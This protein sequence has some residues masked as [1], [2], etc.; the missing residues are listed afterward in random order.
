MTS[1]D[2]AYDA[3]IHGPRTRA[4]QTEMAELDADFARQWV[5]TM[6]ELVA[7]NLPDQE[8]TAARMVA[9]HEWE[10]A[11]KRAQKS[12]HYKYDP[13]RRARRLI[14]RDTRLTLEDARA[15]ATALRERLDAATAALT[16]LSTTDPRT[17]NEPPAVGATVA[18]PTT[19]AAPRR[20]GL[21]R[22]SP[23]AAAFLR[24]LSPSLD[25]ETAADDTIRDTWA[26]AHPHLPS[27][28]IDDLLTFLNDPAHR[29]P[30]WLA[31]SERRP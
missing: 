9:L 3:F 14:E 18:T 25:L 12:L 20:V 8:F 29:M 28:K 23:Y 13:V 15:R 22:I 2:P 30:T 17:S 27:D 24:R 10:R 11:R 4:K 7:R 16:Q 19:V 5:D 1:P 26:A 21:S 31:V 6:T